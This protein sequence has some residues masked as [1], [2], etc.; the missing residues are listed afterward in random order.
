MTITRAIEIANAAHAGQT[1]KA[2]VPY[3]L[4]A[5]RVMLR[6]DTDETRIA[7]VLHDVLEDGL[8]EWQEVVRRELEPRTLEI[9]GFLTR[10]NDETYE[11][12]IQRLAPD[13][14]ARRVKMADL[15]DNLDVRRLQHLGQQDAERISKYLAALSYL[16]IRD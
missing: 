14:I 7:A 5:L 10:R 4:H 9:I 15:E 2:G 8:E 1:D 16:K 13:T 11:R 3:I 12:F 6:M